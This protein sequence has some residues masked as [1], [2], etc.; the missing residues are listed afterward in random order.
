MSFYFSFE[1]QKPVK[2][3][4][5]EV[6]NEQV[7]ERQMRGNLAALCNANSVMLNKI[8]ITAL[9]GLALA[10]FSCKKEGDSWGEINASK[11]GLNWS[12]N[13]IETYLNRLANSKV[14]I[15]LNFAGQDGTQESLLFFK[16]PL[17]EGRYKLSFTTTQPPDNSLAGGKF[18]K[19]FEDELYDV[20]EIALNDS[21][22][23]LEITEYDEK[24]GELKGTFSLQLWPDLANSLNAPDSIVFSN[25]V[26]HTRIRD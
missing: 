6:K 16:I 17:D 24:K 1:E 11:N 7:L 22:S 15:S 26:F 9:F 5:A 4:L 10:F 25:G 12:G 2:E 19:S 18:F 20:Y 21:T 14:D 8:I 23:Y 3:I 13:N